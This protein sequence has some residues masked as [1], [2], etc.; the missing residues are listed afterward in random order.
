M[1]AQGA[2]VVVFGGGCFW[3]TEAVFL[4]LK[5]VRSVTS[6]YAGG[7]TKRSTYE[8]VSTGTTGHAEVVR[9][10]YDP[11]VIPFRKLL[12]VFYGAHDPTTLNRQGA[13]IGSQYRSIILYTDE[14]QKH[15]AEGYSAE[16]AAAKKFPN[17]IVTELKPLD[18]FWPAE[19]YHQTYYAK[20]LDTPYAE[21]V[22]APKV[23]KVRR[24]HAQF[25]LLKSDFDS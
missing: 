18:R 11:A 20:N 19:A 12:E 1:I 8:Q 10:E 16:L 13:D 21:A 3:C 17:P 14:S 6:G 5:G 15:E 25:L 22:I 24:E 7:G 4:Q 9:V 23:E 2:K